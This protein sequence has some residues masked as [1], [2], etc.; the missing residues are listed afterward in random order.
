MHD[1]K[2]TVRMPAED[3]NFAK[4]YAQA[5]GVTMTDLILRFF[6]GLR[7]ERREAIHPEIQAITGLLP[8]KID[9]RAEHRKHLIGKLR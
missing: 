5:H 1:A 6:R 4:D 2:L 7:E 9:A 3:L 8:Q